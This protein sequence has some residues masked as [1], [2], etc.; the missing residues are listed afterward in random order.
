MTIVAEL[1]AL[2]LFQGIEEARLQELV[3]TFKQVKRERGTVLFR[4]GDVAQT[5]DLLESGEVVIEEGIEGRVGARFQLKPLAPV[6]ELGAL[7]GIPRSTTATASTAITLRSIAVRDLLAFFDKHAD[8]GF[9]FYKNLLGV[10]SDKV[11][12][13]RLRLEE[14]RTNII[15]TQKS[16][17]RLR[18]L[19]LDAK[20]TE[21]SKPVFEALETLI[22]KNRRANYRVSP[23]PAFPAQVRLD[24]GKFARVVELSQGYMKLEGSVKDLTN[25]KN[26]WSGVL[27]MPTGEILVSGIIFREDPGAVVVKLDTLI[28][29]FK[30]QFD[31]YTTRLQLLDFVV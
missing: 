5:F 11:R 18:E 4:P 25:D 6:G 15:G 20:E 7:T 28:D 8:I 9:A 30:A 17:K 19:V 1:K 2:P 26:Y 12:R 14:M 24:S 10:V 16:M 27:V 23:V 31:D 13:D 22:E 3:A 21:I 29:E